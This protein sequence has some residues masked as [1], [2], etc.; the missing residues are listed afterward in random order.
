MRILIWESDDHHFTKLMVSNSIFKSLPIVKYCTC[1]VDRS[2]FEQNYPNPW[3]ALFRWM[4]VE[5]LHAQTEKTLA[6]ALKACLSSFCSSEMQRSGIVLYCIVLY[7]IVLY[8]SH[9][10]PLLAAVR[11]KDVILQLAFCASIHSMMQSGP[12][13]AGLIVNIKANLNS[14]Q[15]IWG[16]RSKNLLFYRTQSCPKVG[17]AG[18]EWSS[19]KVSSWTWNADPWVHLFCEHKSLQTSV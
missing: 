3:V 15:N 8:W 18:L 14:V 6:S 12:L 13:L 4:N 11:S 1:W 9:V 19:R 2:I 17:L 16:Y 5:H 7:N 10:F